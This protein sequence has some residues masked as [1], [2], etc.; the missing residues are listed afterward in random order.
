MGLVRVTVRFRECCKHHQAGA[1]NPPTGRGRLLDGRVEARADRHRGWRPQDMNTMVQQATID[2]QQLLAT[3][4][5][6]R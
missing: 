6:A 5:G 1:S 2:L 3:R 4:G